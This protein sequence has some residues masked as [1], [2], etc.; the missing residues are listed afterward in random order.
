MSESDESLVLLDLFLD[1]SRQ[2]RTLPDYLDLLLSSV[3]LAESPPALEG[4]PLY[5]LGNESALL[6]HSHLS[7][8]GRRVQTFLTSGQVMSTAQLIT[9]VL[10]QRAEAALGSLKHPQSDEPPKKRRK[11]REGSKDHRDPSTLVL[12]FSFT[13]KLAAVVLPSLPLQNLA[14]DAARDAAELLLTV[15]TTF[16]G[17]VLPK[18]F[19][20]LRKARKTENRFPSEVATAAA[21]RL[22]FTLANVPNCSLQ[23]LDD[24]LAH[25]LIE[26]TET[27]RGECNELHV[28]IV[29]K[30]MPVPYYQMTHFSPKF[31]SLLAQS[32]AGGPISPSEVFEK[33]F[34]C[35]E[36]SGLTT[37][38]KNT[39]HWNGLVSHLSS[40]E[41][42][43]S[44]Q[45]FALALIRL[46]TRR[47]FPVLECV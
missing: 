34:A 42:T 16:S 28:E 32:V 25:S 12:S 43:A 46:I 31:R 17:Y 14:G 22:C 9:Q 29:S 23:P 6:S 21:L 8:V 40:A 2:T 26:F 36:I 47:W 39:D 24:K 44:N 20:A 3:S 37:D 5:L 11:T 27:T 13:E 7:S 38:I 10:Q 33:L 35:L 1:F 19:K 41:G 18:L 15:Q 30:P 4:P 45:S